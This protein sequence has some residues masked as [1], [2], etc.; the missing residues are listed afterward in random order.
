MLAFAMF[1]FG[2]RNAATAI[3]AAP[4]LGP[5]VEGIVKSVPKIF[6]KKKT[7]K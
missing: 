5:V 1:I 4:V 2:I 6:S 7:R 3:V